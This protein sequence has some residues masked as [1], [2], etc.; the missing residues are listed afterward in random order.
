VTTDLGQTPWHRDCGPILYLTIRRG[1][2]AGTTQASCTCEWV[3]TYKTRVGA[4]RQ[5]NAHLRL[6]NGL[7][8][9]HQIG[10]KPA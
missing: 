5:G 6:A 1:P 7:T 2:K 3:R 4:E 9:A 8:L 10:D